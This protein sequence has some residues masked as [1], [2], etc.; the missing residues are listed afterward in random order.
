MTRRIL[1]IGLCLSALGCRT[2]NAFYILYNMKQN[3][4]MQA[5]IGTPMI[6]VNTYQKNAEAGTQ[7]YTFKY[8]LVYTRKVDS[9]LTITHKSSGE[10]MGIPDLIEELT[11]DLAVS[12]TLVYKETKIQVLEATPAYIRYKV[13]ESPHYKYPSGQRMDI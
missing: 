7:G 3:E 12:D 2:P 11:Y 6:W 10:R 13:L 8:E 1:L 4:V 5:E 9:I